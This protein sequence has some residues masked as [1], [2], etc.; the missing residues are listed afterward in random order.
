M[1][2]VAKETPINLYCRDGV[3]YV[4]ISMGGRDYR[5][6]L[7]TRDIETAQERAA[8]ATKEV[9]DGN[10]QALSP[11]LLLDSL[12]AV[13]RL[14]PPARS[15]YFIRAE[16]GGLVKIG[17]SG[18]PTARLRSMQVGC[19]GRL[20]LLAAFKAKPFA[21]A[22]LHTRFAADRVHG[23]WFTMSPRIRRFIEMVN[24]G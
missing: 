13:T 21:E 9:F 3:W 19:P 18:N 22:A 7:L 14:K 6:S 4:R 16:A 2:E 24:A 8:V 1:M 20:L 23:E 10:P 11:R 15:I 5:R 17:V 12:R